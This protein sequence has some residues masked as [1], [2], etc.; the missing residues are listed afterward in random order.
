MIRCWTRG[1]SGCRRGLWRV[2]SPSSKSE[3]IGSQKWARVPLTKPFPMVASEYVSSDCAMIMPL[4][5]TLKKLDAAFHLVSSTSWAFTR[6]SE[7]HTSELQSLMR[8]S[9]AVFCLKKKNKNNKT[10]II[11]CYHSHTMYYIKTQ[12]YIHQYH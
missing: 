8:L 9:Y 11:I 7:E 10:F 1:L 5:R 2:G 6:R 3:P 4:R 12:Y